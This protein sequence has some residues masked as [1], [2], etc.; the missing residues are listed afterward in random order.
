MARQLLPGPPAAARLACC[1]LAAAV[2]LGSASAAPDK[3]IQFESACSY[4]ISLNVVGRL[5][6]AVSAGFCDNGATAE[7]D[8]CA[9]SLTLDPGATL[10][11]LRS[12]SRYLYYYAYASKDRGEYK[13]WE[14]AGS[15]ASMWLDTQTD[16]QCDGGDDC[17]NYIKA[18]T[19]DSCTD[20]YTVTLT[21]DADTVWTPRS[22]P[23]APVA[24][25][26]D[27]EQKFNLAVRV[28][29]PEAVSPGY[30]LNDASQAGDWCTRQWFG[31]EPSEATRLN[32]YINNSLLYHYGRM[33]GD[34]TYTWSGKD[35]GWTAKW[36]SLE[37]GEPCSE[38]DGGGCVAFRLRDFPSAGCASEWDLGTLTCNNYRAQSPEASPPPPSTPHSTPPAPPSLP[39]LPSS[40][41]GMSTGVIAG[42]A[43]AGAATVCFIRRR[44]VAGASLPT[45]TPSSGSGSTH[46]PA[47]AA[48]AAAAAPAITASLPG[49]SD[50]LDSFVVHCPPEAQRVHGASIDSLVSSPA[51]GGLGSVPSPG[52]NIDSLVSSPAMGG[53]GSVPSPS[54]ALD[55]FVSQPSVAGLD[56]FPAGPPY[57]RPLR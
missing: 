14:G 38:G 30:C 11:A 43:V 27:C 5:G 9:R 51:M 29:L 54:A 22:C 23:P 46:K 12:N 26:S 49:Q 40:T 44:R 42:I 24:V 37:S 28:R 39:L 55:S 20:P 13:R 1:L 33:D 15:A 53:L 31:I 50:E 52:A 18:D 34:D 8:W 19:G 25:T 35:D 41:K 17:R 36:Y 47:P 48:A 57:G 6:A 7:D 56:A 32:A 21:C 3:P 10:E 2:L 16:N 45:T 4:T